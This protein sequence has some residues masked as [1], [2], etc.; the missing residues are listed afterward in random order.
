MDTASQPPVQALLARVRERLA[1]F[2]EVP[3]DPD[4]FRSELE[5]FQRLLER[6]LPEAVDEATASWISYLRHEL[7]QPVAVLS[8][9]VE[10][11]M[12]HDRVLDADTRGELYQRSRRQVLLMQ[13]I[14]DQLDQAYRL[15]SGAFAVSPQQVDVCR[16]IR[17]AVEDFG[18]LLDSAEVQ[19]ELPSHPISG[20]VDSAA[21]QEILVALL[22][23]G[24][25][26]APCERPLLVVAS[27]ADHMVQVEVHDDGPG[28]PER[29]R[30][31]IFARGTQLD[32]SGRGMG[33]GLFVARGL[34]KA[35]DGELTAA[36]SPRRGGA[37]FTVT[38]PSEC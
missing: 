10:T 19:L 11:L 16:V 12:A 27:R 18:P 36:T 24:A 32:Q 21:L 30:E 28:V 25:A 1:E 7:L 29:D 8:G 4:S 5:D 20:C 22:R 34:A 2:D 9:V 35:H 33:L 17:D 37:L 15:Q 3:D 38:L 26:H 6:E 13:R 23:N 14:L 31:R